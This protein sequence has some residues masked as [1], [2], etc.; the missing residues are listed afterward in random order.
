MGYIISLFLGLMGIIYY[1]LGVNKQLK[2]DADVQDANNQLAEVLSEKE[3]QDA[4]AKKAQEDYGRAR[5][6]L[7]AKRK[8]NPGD[9]DV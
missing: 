2:R 9:G 3:K 8:S 7:L 4:I 6:E 1:L 5:T